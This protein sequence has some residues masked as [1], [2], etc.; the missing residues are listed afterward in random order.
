[1]IASRLCVELEAFVEKVRW[2]KSSFYASNL[3]VRV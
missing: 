3:L 1:M 2:P